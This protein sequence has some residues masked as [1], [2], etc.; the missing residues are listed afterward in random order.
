MAELET[1]EANA[2]CCSPAAQGECCEPEAKGECCG[3][4]ADHPGG[5]CGCSAGRVDQAE[6]IRETVR[7][8]Y[9]AAARSVTEAKASNEAVTAS[10]GCGSP[11]IS[12]IKGEAFGESLYSGAERDSLPDAAELASLGCGN[13]TAVADL[14]EGDAVLDLG[15]GGGSTSS[16]RL[17]EL[18]RRAW[19]TDWT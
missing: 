5:T 17:A 2:T 18:A 19:P 9:A 16:S 13:P 15:S 8:R 3:S 7:E 14:R 12:T 6:E 1:P 4:A 11:E 10:C